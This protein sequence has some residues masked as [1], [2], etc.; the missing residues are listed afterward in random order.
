MSPGAALVVAAL[1]AGAGARLGAQ[2]PPPPTYEQRIGAQ[3]PLGTVLRAEDGRAATLGSCFGRQPAIVIFGYFRCPQLC[4]VVQQGAVDALRQIGPSVGRDFSVIYVSIDPTDSA[5]DARQQR[6]SAARLYGRGGS[7]EGW[8][9]LT[10]TAEATG[11]VAAA[12][13]FGYRY[14]RLTRRYVHPSGF[15]VATPSGIVSRYFLGLDFSRAEVAD[16]LERAGRGE[17]GQP[18]YELVL[19]C[20]RGDGI[21]GRYGKVIW[22][23]LQA[24]VGTT[25]LTVFGGI[26]WMLRQERKGLRP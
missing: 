16:A 5:E 17:T 1:L 24:A 19:E 22:R 3:L 21:A 8:H 2:S 25:V 26:G 12:A 10:G 13:G 7:T 9:Y 4:S 11:A 6:T 23:V 14:D 20:F 15:L 18:V